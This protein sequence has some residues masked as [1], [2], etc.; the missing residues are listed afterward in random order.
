VREAV[1]SVLSSRI[2]LRDAAVCDLYC[3]SGAMGIEA[4]S[5]GAASC[6]FVDADEGC[7]AA[8]RANLET[9]RLE[10]RTARFVRAKL[11]LG[12]PD[13]PFDLVCCDP[14]YGEHDLTALLDG[15]AAPM[16]VVESDRA[17]DAVAGW[18]TTFA[19]RYGGTLVTVLQRDDQQGR[20]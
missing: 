9:V 1:F 5:R 2:D 4:L 13:G 19:R 17:L 11:P 7:L 18:E 10:G 3:G 16:V 15:L 8:A 6:T 14:P 12:R 20:S